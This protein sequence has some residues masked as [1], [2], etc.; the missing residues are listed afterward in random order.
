MNEII[1]AISTC[2]ITCATTLIAVY[3]KNK[4]KENPLG[5]MNKYIINNINNQ[6]FKK[7]II[8]KNQNVKDKDLV[9]IGYIS[10]GSLNEKSFND[11]KIILETE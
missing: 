5:E 1:I 7:I 10:K 2:I 4:S 8:Y 3:I 11:I 9:D 6:N